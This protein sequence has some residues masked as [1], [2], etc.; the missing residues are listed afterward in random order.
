LHREGA[1]LVDFGGGSAE[2]QPALFVI[3]DVHVEAHRS[4]YSGEAPRRPGHRVR[5]RD[6]VIALEGGIVHRLHVNQR[7]ESSNASSKT[8]TK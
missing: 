2:N 6:D 7:V 8:L 1:A 3:F 4:G 5:Q